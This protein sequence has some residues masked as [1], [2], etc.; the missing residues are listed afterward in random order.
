M[1]SDG[2]TAPRGDAVTW[3]QRRCLTRHGDLVSLH[4]A[5]EI[6]DEERIVMHICLHVNSEAKT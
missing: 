4:N 2:S 5:P 1:G 3:A 6:Q